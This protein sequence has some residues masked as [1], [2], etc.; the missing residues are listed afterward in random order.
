MSTPGVDGVAVAGWGLYSEKAQASCGCLGLGNIVS[1]FGHFT[2][3]A[4]RL[5]RFEFQVSQPQVF[6]P[7]TQLF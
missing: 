5:F 3:Q 1:H 7:Y 2:I 4:D 6:L